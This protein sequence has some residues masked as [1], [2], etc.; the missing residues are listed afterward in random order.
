MCLYRDENN[1]QK[2]SCCMAANATMWSN[3]S[4][5]YCGYWR[6]CRVL[7]WLVGLQEVWEGL[8]EGE[9]TQLTLIKS[10]DISLNTS[11][12]GGLS[13]LASL[14]RGIEEWLWGAKGKMA[15]VGDVCSRHSLGR[16]GTHPALR[17]TTFSCIDSYTHSLSRTEWVYRAGLVQTCRLLTIFFF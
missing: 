14:P 16:A 11:I 10:C 5:H 8:G 17:M 15:I 1:R 3:N 2:W 4:K 13:R 12:S 6:F 7:F 9:G